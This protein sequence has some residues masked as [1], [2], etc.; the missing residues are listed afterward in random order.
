M[1]TAQTT[2]TIGWTEP[3][4]GIR[5][6]MLL[7]GIIARGSYVSFEADDVL[8]MQCTVRVPNCDAMCT[9]LPWIG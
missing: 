6:Q 1:F 3:L 8:I 5:G 4:C 7:E 2:I 9:V